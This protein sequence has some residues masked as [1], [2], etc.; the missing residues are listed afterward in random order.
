MRPL[1]FAPLY[2]MLAD[3]CVSCRIRVARLGAHDSHAS[4]IDDLTQLARHNLD[5]ETAQEFID[6]LRM[7]VPPPLP[8]S[9]RGGRG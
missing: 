9:T 6:S 3:H 5:R 7:V 1:N 8:P 2:C 4:D